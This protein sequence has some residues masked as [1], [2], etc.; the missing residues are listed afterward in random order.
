[1]AEIEF[2][3]ARL[4]DAAAVFEWRNDSTSRAASVSTGEISWAGHVEWFESALA[5]PLR[6][7]YIAVESDSSAV[8]MCRFDE[9][10]DAAEVSINL[11][12]SVR[13]KGI[14]S[15]VLRGAIDAYRED[16][17]GTGR[18]T[19]VI[20]PSNTASVRLFERLGFT[21]LGGDGEFDRYSCDL[22]ESPLR[23]AS[24]KI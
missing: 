3:R 24:P 23:G 21:R 8:G 19:A 22:A 12:P 16:H 20:R 10:T 4:S 13:G 7:I 9:R 2:R 5:D 6:E 14:A 17:P 18:L 1:M 15:V 11:A